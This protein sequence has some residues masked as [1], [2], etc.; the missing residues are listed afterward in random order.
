MAPK[1]VAGKHLKA[2]FTIGALTVGDSG[3]QV[4]LVV[5]LETMLK[6]TT[7]NDFAKYTVF[8]CSRSPIS[9]LTHYQSSVHTVTLFKEVIWDMRWFAVC[10]SKREEW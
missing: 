7:T 4:E 8:T 5:I 10:N 2:N 1:P 9:M 3:C 6:N